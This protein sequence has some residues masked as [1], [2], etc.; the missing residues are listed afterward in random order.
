M[1][2]PILIL[3]T[4]FM[5][6]MFGAGDIKLFSVI[7]LFLGPEKV[8]Q[9]IIIS[10]LLGAVQSVIKLITNHN[11]KQR[12]KYFVQYIKGISYCGYSQYYEA[13]GDNY[14]NAI[15]FSISIFA[16]LCLQLFLLGGD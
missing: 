7:G 12:A 16:A 13:K 4:L 10:F 3:I 1:I 14:K 11:L 6:R 9:V 8:L 15:H 2:L 5:F